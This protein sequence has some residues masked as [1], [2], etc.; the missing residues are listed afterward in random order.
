ML[1]R[2]IKRQCVIEFSDRETGRVLG[3]I[4][5]LNPEYVRDR[6]LIGMDFKDD[7]KITRIG[8]ESPYKRE[9]QDNG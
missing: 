4:H 7:I 3:A 5:F 9:G 1:K 2:L 6:V 8:G